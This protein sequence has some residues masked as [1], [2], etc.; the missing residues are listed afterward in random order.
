[1][2][3]VSWKAS[4][5]HDV[6][7]GWC[8]W[9]AISSLHLV[10]NPNQKTK[11]TQTSHTYYHWVWWPLERNTY[12]QHLTRT[13]FL[14]TLLHRTVHT[15]HTAWRILDQSFLS[16]A[17]KSHQHLFFKWIRSLHMHRKSS[18]TLC[19]TSG[20]EQEAPY[21][22]WSHSPNTVRFILQYLLMISFE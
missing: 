3:M 16:K 8:M 15:T 12:I 14:C 1:M 22:F 10:G 21:S 13:P 2:E 6:G 17:C 9:R 7:S 11:A 19:N 18:C 5:W 4:C 20:Q